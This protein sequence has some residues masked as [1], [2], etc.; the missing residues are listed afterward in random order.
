MIRWV[1]KDI[2]VEPNNAPKYPANTYITGYI[3]VN[4]SGYRVEYL[5]VC[6]EGVE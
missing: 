1:V 5:R 4:T 6:V 3:Y 2:S